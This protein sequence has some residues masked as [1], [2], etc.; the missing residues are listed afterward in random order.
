MTIIGIFI[1]IPEKWKKGKVNSE[2]FRNASR[3][4]GASKTFGS[5]PK[6]AGLHPPAESGRNEICGI[7]SNCANRKER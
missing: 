6:P 2:P 7:I 3:A 1:I 4:L 5:Y